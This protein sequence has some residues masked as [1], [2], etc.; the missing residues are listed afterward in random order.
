MA[1][2][3]PWGGGRSPGTVRLVAGKKGARLFWFLP[4][5]GRHSKALLRLVTGHLRH[6]RISRSRE[7]EGVLAGS[8]PP[9]NI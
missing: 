2:L 4:L 1:V 3:L 8:L 5:G 9:P 6:A 7:L